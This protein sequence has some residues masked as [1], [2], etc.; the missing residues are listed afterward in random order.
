ML[1]IVLQI[2]HLLEKVEVVINPLPVA[3]INPS[4][5]TIYLGEEVSLTVGN[6]SFYEWY[7]DSDS[8]ISTQSILT[9]QDSGK[10]KVWVEDE[11][12]CTDISE[13][14]IVRSVPLT[15]IFVPSVLHQMLMSIMSC[16][17]L[18]VFM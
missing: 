3:V 2:L 9:V 6:Y 1:I 8:L 5:I 12:G 14:A 13:L 11:N 18:K 4:D 7:T 10:Y 16:L 15:Q 17:L